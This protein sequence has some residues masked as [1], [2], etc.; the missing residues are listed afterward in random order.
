MDDIKKRVS[1]L[2]P[3]NPPIRFRF[4]GGELVLKDGSL[5]LNGDE[6]RVV[7]RKGIAAFCLSPDG[8]KVAYGVP[9]AGGDILDWSV[10]DL[11]SKKEIGGEP[12]RVHMETVYWDQRSSGIFYSSPASEKEEAAGVQGKRIRYRPIPAGVHRQRG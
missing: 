10:W 3:P 6:K 1:S 12:V 11:A 5:F 4:Q 2:S 9:V 7:P 8:T